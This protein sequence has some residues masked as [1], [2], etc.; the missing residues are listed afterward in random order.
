L[1][2]AQAALPKNKRR[3]WS[4][5]LV[6]LMFYLQPIIRGAA[7]YAGRLRLRP[8]QPGSRETLDSV[9]LRQGTEPLGEI[10]YW[11]NQRVDRVEFVKRLLV[12]LDRRAWP[13]R[14]DIGWSEFDV[15]IYGDRW[16]H[17]QLTTVAEEHPAG[18]QLMRCRLRA[19][20]SLQ[21]QIVLCALLALETIAVGFFPALTWYVLVSA[22]VVTLLAFWY[23][24]S[25]RKR[26]LQSLVTIFLDELAKEWNFIRMARGQTAPAKPAP[27]TGPV[28]VEVPS[29]AKRASAGKDAVAT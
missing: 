24:V 23:F 5:P 20:W 10:R 9:T 17:L 6:A 14:S 22:L 13:H 3:W 27:K 21:A 12:E 29:Q 19:R 8:P 16:C 26:H 18:R 7:R 1:A 4:R 25:T 28:R 15:E 11:S 2:G